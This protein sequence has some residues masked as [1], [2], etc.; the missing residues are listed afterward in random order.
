MGFP[1][2]FRAWRYVMGNLAGAL[3]QFVAAG[4]EVFFVRYA[5]KFSGFAG[6]VVMMV[7]WVWLLNLA[8]S[9]SQDTVSHCSHPPGSVSYFRGYGAQFVSSCSH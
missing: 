5:E 8:T 7:A 9:P 1:A 6:S 2:G 3:P 4:A